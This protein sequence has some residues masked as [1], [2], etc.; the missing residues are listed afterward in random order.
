MREML[1]ENMGK[2]NQWS[3]HCLVNSALILPLIGSVQR[4]K[5]GEFSESTLK[6][7][8]SSPF[9]LLQHGALVIIFIAT[10]C[11]NNFAQSLK[12]QRENRTIHKQFALEPGDRFL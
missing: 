3:V 11:V 1:N 10:N 2:Y 5:L 6:S 7:S 8:I 4:T 9:R 12:R